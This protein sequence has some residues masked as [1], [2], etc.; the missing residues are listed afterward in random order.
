ME[1]ARD[2]Y[3]CYKNDGL[4]DEVQNMFKETTGVDCMTVVVM[5][6][7]YGDEQGEERNED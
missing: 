5:S 2:T 6:L 3:D 1:D 7:G 4:M